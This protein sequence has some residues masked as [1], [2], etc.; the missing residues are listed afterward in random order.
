MFGGVEFEDG[1]DWVGLF[2]GNGIDLG[3]RLY[4]W[5]G[6]NCESLTMDMYICG[7]VKGLFSKLRVLN[8]LCSGMLL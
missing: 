8:P 6:L 2:W 4:I 5:G 7:M 1:G 3:G